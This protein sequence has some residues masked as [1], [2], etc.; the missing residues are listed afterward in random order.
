MNVSLQA[1]FVNFVRQSV[2][3]PWLA[4]SEIFSPCITQAVIL[5]KEE[6]LKQKGSEERVNHYY[7]WSEDTSIKKLQERLEKKEEVH[8]DDTLV[9]K[10]KIRRAHLNFR[11][12]LLTQPLTL[13]LGHNHTESILS[14]NIARFNKEYQKLIDTEFCLYENK[15]IF[16]DDAEIRESINFF[17]LLRDTEGEKRFE[18]ALAQDNLLAAFYRLL[19]LREYRQVLDQFKDEREYGENGLVYQFLVQN[20]HTSPTETN[21]II[22]PKLKKLRRI[23]LGQNSE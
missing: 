15:L 19:S 3:V 4:S 7:S 18:Y 11:I 8:E 5:D 13:F 12:L 23:L 1:E 14:S 21:A 17:F 2:G 16:V 9:Q 20:Y 10:L 22:I 6:F